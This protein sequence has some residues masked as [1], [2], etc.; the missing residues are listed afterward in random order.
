MASAVI[1][2]TASVIGGGKFANGAQTGAFGYLFNRLAHIGVSGRVPFLGGG[3]A[4]LGVSWQDGQLDAGLIFEG[5]IP[6]V[7]AGKMLGKASVEAGYQPGDFDSARGSMDTQVQAHYKMVGGSYSYDTNTKTFSGAS[8]SVGPGL[9]LSVSG[10]RTN[11]I[12][13]RQVYRE[14]ARPAW[15]WF[16]ERVGQ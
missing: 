4:S 10:I 6:A 3:S 1:G 7:N 16:K 12:S 13:V 8:V 5:D 9:G 15:N 2:G 11:T 14:V